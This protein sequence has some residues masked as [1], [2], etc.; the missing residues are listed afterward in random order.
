M[1]AEAKRLKGSQRNEERK[2]E[3]YPISR[4]SGSFVSTSLYFV[5]SVFAFLVARVTQRLRPTGQRLRGSVNIPLDLVLEILTKLPAKSGEVL[6]RLKQWSSIIISRSVCT[7]S[8]I[9]IRLNHSSS[10]RQLT[11][12]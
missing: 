8:S 6:M 4:S 9:T 11:I 2:R 1:T 3:Y 12:R 10:S 7:S 5:K